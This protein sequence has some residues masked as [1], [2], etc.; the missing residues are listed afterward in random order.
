[1][2]KVVETVTLRNLS[3]AAVVLDGWRI[4][5]IRGNQLHATLSGSLAAGETRVIPSQS[6]TNVWSDNDSDDG[7]LYDAKGSLISFWDN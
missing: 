4:C 2:D 5:S 6:G 1:M 3:G 7:A